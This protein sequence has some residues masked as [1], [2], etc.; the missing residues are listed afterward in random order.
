MAGSWQLYSAQLNDEFSCR[1]PDTAV[2]HSS[3]LEATPVD[4]FG[5]DDN[6]TALLVSESGAL[7][8]AIVSRW[9]RPRDV[10]QMDLFM[11]NSIVIAENDLGEALAARRWDA[12]AKALQRL[13][14][15][16]PGHRQLGAYADVLNYGQHM[17]AN[18]KLNM[19]AVAPELDGLQREVSPLAKEL[20]RA[21]A[22]DYL[23]F[24]WR[25]TNRDFSFQI[26]RER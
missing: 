7:H 5:W 3:K 4:Y 11:D 16:N 26:E 15:L 22:R 14:R 17:Q 2:G 20:L 25:E 12:A 9:Q 10:M 24:A 23:A 19:A 8:Q 21:N 13:T 1:T 6:R 18:M